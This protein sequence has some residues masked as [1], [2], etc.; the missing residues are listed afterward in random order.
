M[1]ILLYSPASTVRRNGNR[2][3]SS[4]WVEMLREAGHHVRILSHYENEQADLLIALHATKSREAILGF[5]Q[6]VPGGKVIL[7]LTG[8]DIYPSPAEEAIDTMMR[9]DAL[10]TLQ[11]KA[12]E[13]VPKDCQTKTFT[14]IQSA[15]R[16]SNLAEE[17]T[18]GVVVSVVGHLRDVKDPL[19][20][21]RASRL[22]NA[23]SE[24]RIRHA[25]GILETKYAALVAAEEKENP[26]YEWLGELSEIETANLIASSH[27]M[28]ISSLS[29]GGARVVGEAVVH[30]TPVLSSRIDG[31]IGL[32]GDDYPGLFPAGSA[33]SLAKMLSKAER[34]SFFYATLK[35]AA[36]RSA[37][38]FSPEAEKTSLLSIIQKFEQGQKAPLSFPKK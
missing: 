36:L 29:E 21:A 25:G 35:K 4:Q 11:R 30:G 23:S 26:R 24:I 12:V 1:N 22:L 2:Q 31:V 38:Q 6:S 18:H 15:H 20:P 27:L 9:A 8:T 17:S 28:V 19:L 34:D 13:K 33:S 37:E 5:Q 16:R 14:V 10:I 32:L 3:T 7:T